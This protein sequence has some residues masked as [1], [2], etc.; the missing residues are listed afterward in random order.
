MAKFVIKQISNRGVQHPV[1]A[2]LSIQTKE[3][4]GFSSICQQ[5][6]DNILRVCFSELQS[7]LGKCWDIWQKIEAEQGNLIRGYKPS[8][9]MV[10]QIPHVYGLDRDAD[11]F[12]YEAKNFLRDLV[13]LVVKKFHPG[14]NC[15]DASCLF[16]AKGNGDGDLIKKWAE[17]NFGG[18]D[19]MTT[20]LRDDQKWIAELVRK[21][22]AIEHPGGF[23]GHLTI[24]NFEA[25]ED[26]RIIVP[27]WWRT[28]QT[29]SPIVKDME[30]Y[31]HNLLTFAEE[32]IVIHGIE[33]TSASPMIT[34]GEIAE[35]D[36]N[37]ECPVRFKA[38][39][40]EGVLPK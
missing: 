29:P 3:L 7:R 38:I 17:P 8:D 21:R 35:Q 15:S 10:V 14:I 16:D 2:R 31:C 20:M 30:I 4:I 39:F 26:G 28:G 1:V 22:N 24:Q 18:N 25:V 5:S 37:P 32:L 40:K 23:S 13:N 12:L 11:N 27:A 34:F 9:A 33:K 19:R 36:R 6:K